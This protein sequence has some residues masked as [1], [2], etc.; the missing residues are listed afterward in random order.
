[1]QWKD[2][3]VAYWK[4]LEQEIRKK[5][6]D[7]LAPS[8]KTWV[9]YSDAHDAVSAIDFEN[10]TAL[11]E[12]QVATSLPNP[13][14]TAR[15]QVTQIT[16]ALL[17]ANGMG[18]A[19]SFRNLF[20]TDTQDAIDLGALNPKAIE[21]WT[22]TDGIQRRRFSVRLPFAMGHIARLSARYREEIL[23][24]SR[25]HAVDPALVHAI[26]H[27]ESAFNPMARSHTPAFGLMQ[28]VPRF[29][30]RET[31]AALYGI[32]ALPS[33]S[34]LYHPRNNI[35]L[36]VAYL[37]RLSRLYFSEI[38][39][40]VKRRLLVIAAYNFGPR[41]VRRAIPLSSIK[42]MTAAQLY[43]LLQRNTPKE[44]QDYLRRVEERRRLYQGM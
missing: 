31:Y 39:D 15:H 30:G 24:F 29:A 27:T 26:V 19:F 44:T 13:E 40:P 17:T 18:G 23:T 41:A 36:G 8:Q 5:W 38:D 21:D 6:R 32:D 37:A 35:E 7:Y 9:R 12:V 20:A 22:G 25:R 34:Y 1:M 10:G 43:D 4:N 2:K 33:P 3:E 28:I 42:K 11:V 14:A 16:Q